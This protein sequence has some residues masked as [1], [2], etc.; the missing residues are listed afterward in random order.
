MHASPNYSRNISQEEAELL[1]GDRDAEYNRRPWR[2]CRGSQEQYGGQ[3][4]A[5]IVS[6]SLQSY[7]IF[8]AVVHI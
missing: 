5:A 4:T 8:C 1:I 7:G 2:A 6:G 3:S